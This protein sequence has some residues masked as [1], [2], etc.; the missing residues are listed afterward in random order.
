M[1]DGVPH[2]HRRNG[3]RS[4]ATVLGSNRVRGDGV[5]VAD[6]RALPLILEPQAY[7]LQREPPQGVVA[8]RSQRIEGPEAPAQTGT[9]KVLESKLPVKQ[10]RA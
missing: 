9:V 4:P 10:V 3:P 8:K 1:I 2:E 5:E 7:I 6:F